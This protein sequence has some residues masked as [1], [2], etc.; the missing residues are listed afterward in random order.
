MYNFLLLL[1]YVKTKIVTCRITPV[2][3]VRIKISNI[4]AKKISRT[5]LTNCFDFVA[6]VFQKTKIA[7]CRITPVLL[8]RVKI[9]NIFAKNSFKL[10]TNCFDS[11]AAVSSF[12]ST[13]MQILDA[14]GFSRSNFGRSDFLWQVL[15]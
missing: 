3:L 8:V 14:R 13:L 4:F 15:L 6:A 2:L 9:S 10:L 12:S 5:S 1:Y 7:T 11:V